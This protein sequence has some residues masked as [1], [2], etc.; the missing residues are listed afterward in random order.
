MKIFLVIFCFVS[1]AAF[2]DPK[3]DYQRTLPNEWDHISLLFS[4]QGLDYRQFEFSKPEVYPLPGYPPM[5]GS[6]SSSN[7]PLDAGKQV[8]YYA[9]NATL[10]CK[11]HL[12]YYYNSF[13]EPQSVV[14]CSTKR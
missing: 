8:I 6:G 9:S 14:N 4:K 13:Y 2:A 12:I 10:A 3:Q 7:T 11:A 5:V 1:T